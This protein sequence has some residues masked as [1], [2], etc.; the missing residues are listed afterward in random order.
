MRSAVVVGTGLIGTSVALALSAQGVAV[1]LRDA[2][3]EAA[4]MAASLGAGTVEAPTAAVDLAVLAVPPALVGS[5]LADAQA[6]GIARHYTDVASVKAEPREDVVVLGCDTARYIGGHPMAGGE[7]SGPTAAR[8]D[9]FEGCTWVLTPT[10][11]TGT[12]TL[13]TAL[14]LV[15]TCGGTPVVMAAAEHDRVVG[16]VS[17]APHVVAAL[18]AKRLAKAGER[19]VSLAGPGVRD[20]T[21]IAGGDPDLWVDILSANAGVVA[22]ILEELG[23][24]LGDAVAALRAMAAT[25]EAKRDA[26]RQCVDALLR[27]GR[28]GRRRIAGKHGIR[29]ARYRTLGVV[30]GDQPGQLARLFAD[31]DR[32][33]VNIEDIHLEHSTGRLTGVVRLSVDQRAAPALEDALH[34]QGWRIQ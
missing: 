3:P 12:E 23:S 14:E 25:D 24:D 28:S 30:V 26:G 13:N 22:D 8:A 1:H 2:D 18:V 15:A 16:L 20:L 31:A 27:Q 19:A 33:G 6:A 5:V 4:G 7:V 34:S 32:S 11:D 21:R 17:H 9:L 29:P 10:P